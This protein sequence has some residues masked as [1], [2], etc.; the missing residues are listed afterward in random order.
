[1]ALLA[2]GPRPILKHGAQ[3]PPVRRLQRSLTAALPGAVTIH[4]HFGPG[5]SA[6]VQRYQRRAGL[7]VTGVAASPTWRALQRGRIGAPDRPRGHAK[8]GDKHAKHQRN[9]AAKKHGPKQP[10]AKHHKPERESKAAPAK[11][12]R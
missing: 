10:K 8:A 2:A 4:G 1:V 9:Q 12:H 11:R 6:A 5:T 3:G 7:R